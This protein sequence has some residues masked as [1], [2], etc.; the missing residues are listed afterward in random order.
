MKKLLM[1]AAA[2]AVIL[3][4]GAQAADT[5]S[6]SV[7]LSAAA[8]NT[9][10]IRGI[11]GADVTTPFSNTAGGTDSASVAIAFGGSAVDPLTARAIETTKSLTLDA[12]CNYAHVVQLQSANG[13]LTNTATPQVVGSFARR[14][15]YDAKLILWNSDNAG[16][17]LAALPAAGE[18]NSG[19][20][21]LTNGTASSVTTPVNRSTAQVQITTRAGTDNPLLAGTYGDTLRIRLGTGFPTS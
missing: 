12:F 6:G 16:D 13:G 17:T 2:A 20:A 21:S 18:V 1:M 4:M 15:Q 5:A 11:S 10:A 8:P 14:I 9:C 19:T 7:T 3:P